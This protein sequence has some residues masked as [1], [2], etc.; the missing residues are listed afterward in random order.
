VEPSLR[1]LGDDE[2]LRTA[3]SRWLLVQ[4]WSLGLTGTA[5]AAAA[6]TEPASISCPGGGAPV[7]AAATGALD[8]Q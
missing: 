1:K 8:F 3:W 2:D 6:A 4:L 5:A 7:A